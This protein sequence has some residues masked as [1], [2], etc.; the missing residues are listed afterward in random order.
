MIRSIISRYTGLGIIIM[1]A[2]LIV[3]CNNSLQSEQI[4]K[5]AN[6][7]NESSAP[8]VRKG[9][10]SQIP[11]YSKFGLS[12]VS[13]LDSNIWF[14]LK[15]ASSD[16]FMKVKLY[17]KI[18]RPYLQS[19]VARRLIKCSEFLRSID[20]S[21]HLLIYDAVRPVTVQWKM[22]A[23][24]DSIP[25]VDRVKFVSNPRNKS[26]HNYGAAVDLTICKSDRTP[27]DMGAGSMIYV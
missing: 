2:L 11:D 4:V 13:S 8:F 3:S 7:E 24:L 19:D 5:S 27:L 1:V 22:W 20:T 18:D 15:Y 9:I 17:E 26:L 21:L 6:L 23:A 16:N 14:D 10:T 25:P 12:D